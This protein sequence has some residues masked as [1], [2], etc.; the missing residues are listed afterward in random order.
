MHIKSSLQSLVNI[1]SAIDS[2]FDIYILNYGF[3]SLRNHWT[4][5]LILYEKELQS[6]EYN[7]QYINDVQ[8]SYERTELLRHQYNKT[9]LSV[10]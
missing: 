7:E 10:N 3:E 8:E 6:G 1:F 4:I 5:I 2:C 9:L